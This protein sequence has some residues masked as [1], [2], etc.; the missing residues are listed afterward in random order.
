[1]VSSTTRQKYSEAGPGVTRA[2]L[3]WN[4]LIRMMMTKISIIDQRPIFSVI[5]YSRETLRMSNGTP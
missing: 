3:V 1:M 4:V 2:I 5:R